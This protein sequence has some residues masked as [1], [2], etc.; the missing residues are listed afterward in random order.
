MVCSLSRS[1]DV[2]L[3][4]AVQTS[5][6]PAGCGWQG[7]LW[8]SDEAVMVSSPGINLSVASVH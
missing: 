7:K 1:S 4:D 3:V 5:N 6:N 2:I 8:E